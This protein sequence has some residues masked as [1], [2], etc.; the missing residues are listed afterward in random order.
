MFLPRVTTLLSLLSPLFLLPPITQASTPWP[1]PMLRKLTDINVQPFWDTSCNLHSPPS[2]RNTTGHREIYM[3]ETL[4]DAGHCYIL[5]EPT[6]FGSFNFRF[7]KLRS[8]PSNYP[9]PDPP[10]EEEGNQN[11]NPNGQL[12]GYDEAIGGCIIEVYKGYNCG[13]RQTHLIKHWT[14]E[15]PIYVVLNA[16]SDEAGFVNSCHKV[17]ELTKHKGRSFFFDCRSVWLDD[18]WQYK[19][20]P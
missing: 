18:F 7:G 13:S 15:K 8:T 17:T 14:R 10:N 19:I 12:V 4:R 9:Y 1:P 3:K 16:T 5:D 6:W 20:P 11:G 2:A